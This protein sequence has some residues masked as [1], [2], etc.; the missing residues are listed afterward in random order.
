M[1]QSSKL[2]TQHLEDFPSLLISDAD[3]LIIILAVDY[4]QQT[5]TLT[6]TVVQCDDKF[7]HGLG[8]TSITWNA[9]HFSKYS[10]IITLK[11]K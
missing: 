4:N 6:G 11:N 5:D 1:I 9:G 3:P 2:N 10:G 8:Y 7:K